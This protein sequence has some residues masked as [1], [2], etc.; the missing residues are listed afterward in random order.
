MINTNVVVLAGGAG[1]RLRSITKNKIPKPLAKF[2]NKPFLDYLI[3]Y[4]VKFKFKKIYIIT[5][6]LG[7]QI[8]KKYH[9][10]KLKNTM[11]KCIVEK[12]PMGTGG[13][14]NLV[15]KKINRKFLLLNGDTLFKINLDLINKINLN[16]NI[17]LCILTNQKKNT[18]TKKLLNLDIRKNKIITKKSSEY[19][20]SGTY[21]FSSK[22]FSYLSTKKQSLENDIL[23]KLIYQKK[24][25][26]IKRKWLFI[27]IGTPKTFKIA[28][29]ILN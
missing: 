19:I 21:F 10:K 12:K 20:N 4:L 22:V 26:G 28:K 18:Q 17:G 14:L 15:K 2:K 27:D 11:I 1:K 29:K 25:L 16:R 13:A 5:G 24:L 8:K 6:H 7:Y 9:N 3:N 23:K